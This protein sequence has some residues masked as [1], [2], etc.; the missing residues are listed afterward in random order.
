MYGEGP[1]RTAAKVVVLGALH[2]FAILL[3]VARV[4]ALSFFSAPGLIPAVR[5][6]RGR[7][8]LAAGGEA[9]PRR[10]RT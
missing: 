6:G 10:D 5:L 4:G 2:L 1:R 8:L 7:L 3:G 9:P